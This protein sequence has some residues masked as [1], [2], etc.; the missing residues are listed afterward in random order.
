MVTDLGPRVDTWLSFDFHPMHENV[1]NHFASHIFC[2]WGN[3]HK[4]LFKDATE[5]KC[6]SSVTVKSYVCYLILFT[7]SLRTLHLTSFH[8]H[9]IFRFLT[10]YM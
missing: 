3:F 5:I 8:Q 10:N 4:M 7:F 2:A 6:C 9:F 1:M